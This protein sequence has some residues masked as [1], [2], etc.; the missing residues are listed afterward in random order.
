MDTLFASI[1]SHM[2]IVIEHGGYLVLFLVSVLEGVPIVGP[3][4]PGHTIVILSGFLSKI[5]VLDLSYVLALSMAGAFMGDLLGFM[6]GRKFG[7]VFLNRFGKYFFIKDQHVEKVKTIVQK[8]SGKSI[9][10]GRFSPLTRALAPYITGASGVSLRSF[11]FFDLI[12][13]IL[14]A[15][16]SIGLGFVF[17]A[18][19]KVAA[20]FFGKFIL[21]AIIIGVFTVWSYHFI[22]RQFHIFARYE[23]I[24]LFLN[25]SGLYVFF[26]MIQD[27]LVQSSA[28]VGFDVWFNLLLLSNTKPF[29][30]SFFIFMTNTFS[31]TSLMMLMIIGICYF[32]YRKQWRYA[33][34]TFFSYSGGM[35]LSG[36]IKEMVL[37]ARPVDSIVS[38]GGYSFPSGHAT[39]IMIVCVIAI[40][41]LARRFT[42]TTKREM[43]I[44]SLVLLTLLIGFSRLYLGVHW[45]SDVIAGFALGLFWTTFIILA[46]RYLGMFVQ[47]YIH[48]GDKR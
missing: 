26:K 32:L 36:F 38:A 42:S 3:F 17:G 16:V 2:E 23:L 40:Y 18:S 15:C 12:G 35:F 21:A 47:N 10:L 45:F 30:A 14:W 28:I 22:N 6:C 34:I 37:R 33:F 1:L 43:F 29:L 9:I 27:A 11:W 4:V 7:F 24:T 13:V 48:L 31:P 20:V 46:V 39:A 41:T 5:G 44:V 8:H 25:L 19:Y